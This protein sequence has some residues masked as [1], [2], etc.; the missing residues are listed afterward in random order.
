MKSVL[1]LL[2]AVFALT[3]IAARAADATKLNGWISDSMCGAKHLGDNPACVKKCIEG[4]MA[5]VFVDEAQKAV[6]T[7]DNPDAVKAFYG[8][9][10]TITA[11]ADAAKKSV[12]IESIAEAK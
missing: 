8:D 5:P 7:I 3:A 4:G 12:H 10:V 2:L 6:W 9:H 11:T 1:T